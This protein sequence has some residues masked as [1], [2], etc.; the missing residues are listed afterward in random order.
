MGKLLRVL[1]VIMLI[2]SIGA[3]VLS[4]MLFNRREILKGRT[5]KLENTIIALGLV[6]ESEPPA[7]EAVPDYPDRDISPC[8][9]EKVES[10]E[11]SDFWDTYNHALELQQQPTM[12]ISERKIELMTYYKLD[13]ITGKIERD[14]M[15]YKKT[16]GPGTMQ[17]VLDDL[18]VRAR[19]QYDLLTETRQQLVVLRDE[20]I[21]TIQDLNARKNELRDALI[22]ITRLNGVINDLRAEIGRLNDRISELE[23]IKQNLEDQV[24]E[25]QRLLA[26]QEEKIAEKDIEI[27][28]LNEEIKILR[29]QA[30]Q[31]RPDERSP[32]ITRPMRES[33]EPG[34][35]GVVASVDD[36]WNF[37]VLELSDTFL[38]ELLGND[39]SGSVPTLDM[40]IQRPGEP[41]EFVTKVRLLNVKR[42]EGLAIADVLLDWQQMPVKPGDVLAY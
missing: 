8:T 3:L 6:V 5:Q 20:L 11:V 2:L 24:A 15:G 22:E 40:I 18:T 19:S 41:G 25:Q 34:P 7:I 38:R 31:G 23:M 30:G 13:S 10:P 36:E 14:Q 12:D 33:V 16:N 26:V 1:V 9:D 28:E 21:R 27:A 39:L 42:D 35:K 29:V 32:D 37:V 4:I 17:A